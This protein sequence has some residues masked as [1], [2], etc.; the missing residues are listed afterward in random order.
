MKMSEENKEN[1]DKTISAWYA[2]IHLGGGDDVSKEPSPLSHDIQT[3]A[4]P[5]TQSAD[6]FGQGGVKLV[7]SGVEV[8]SLRLTLEF[9]GPLRM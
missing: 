2:A 1:I 5:L 7:C 6:K 3:L 8:S 4:G 9:L